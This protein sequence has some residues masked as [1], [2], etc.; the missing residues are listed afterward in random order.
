[1]PA[2]SDTRRR[3]LSKT[4]SPYDRIRALLIDIDDTITRHAPGSTSEGLLQVLQ[5]AG[6]Q[7][8]GLSEEETALR[9]KRVRDAEPWWHWSDFIVALE[10]DPK[11]FWRYAIEM[12]RK[13]LEPT[14][15]EIGTALKRLRE[16]G[17]LLYVTSNNASSGILYKLSIAGL[18]TIQGA[19]L[20]DQLL[21]CTELHAMKWEPVYWKKV[22]AHIGLDANEV[23]VVGD[24]P[25]DDMEVPQSIGIA[26]SFLINRKDDL[27]GQNSKSV[28]HV[29]CFDSIADCLLKARAPLKTEK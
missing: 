13:C 22:L 28:T 16:A 12:E 29:S 2:S 8:G 27:S 20:F 10:L 9:M 17:F 4:T 26:H 6:V 24:N 19:P 21:G 7:L 23:A 18:A 5:S 15:P 11:E 25:K 1:M 14:G 3:S